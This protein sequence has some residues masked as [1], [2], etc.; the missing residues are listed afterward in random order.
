MK[1][2]H[3]D[4]TGIEPTGLFEVETTAVTLA[5][6]A[7]NDFE[8]FWQQYPRKQAKATAAKSWHRMTVQ[9]HHL[10]ITALVSHIAM[11]NREGR[12]TRLIP[13]ATTWL[14]QQRWEDDLSGYVDDSAPRKPMPGRSG[15][16]AA[17]SNRQQA[18]LGDGAD[19][20]VSAGSD[21]A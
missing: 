19:P 11:W 20:E 12:G 2:S 10:A 21:D 6:W 16:V 14:N 13:M 17:L 9:Q 5:S 8:F 3:C 18:A 1:C 4:G 7:A 15:I